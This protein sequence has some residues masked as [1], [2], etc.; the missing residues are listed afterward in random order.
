MVKCRECY[1][2]FKGNTYLVLQLAKDCET[3]K[4]MVV[5]QNV[6]NGSTWVRS[7]ESFMDVVTVGDKIVNRFEKISNEF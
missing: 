2:H 4:E 3:E 5:Y 6:D 1:K 7:L